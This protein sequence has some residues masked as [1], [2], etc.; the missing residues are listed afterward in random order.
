MKCPKCGHVNWEHA[1]YCG[2]CSAEL[3]GDAGPSEI[4]MYQR[5]AIS[6]LPRH[7]ETV[8]RRLEWIAVILFIVS[9]VAMIYSYALFMSDEGWGLAV[10]AVNMST[11]IV[12]LLSV[13]FSIFGKT[14]LSKSTL[15]I[16]I[17]GLMVL[18]IS[19]GVKLMQTISEYHDWWYY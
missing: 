4:S 10:V 12:L 16:G 5:P 7:D 18:V 15:G 13:V 19:I 2:M 17:I 11:A 14:N 1:V 8:P 6:E 9:F 3:S